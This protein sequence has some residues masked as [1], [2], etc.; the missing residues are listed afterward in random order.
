ML[1]TSS[2]KHNVMVWHLSDVVSP[3]DIFTMSHQGAAYD[4][5][6]THFGLILVFVVG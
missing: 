3:I 1:A 2:G 4:A 6:S 5:I